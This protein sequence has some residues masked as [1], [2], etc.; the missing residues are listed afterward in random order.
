MDS[1]EL[2]PVVSK[3][4]E[5]DSRYKFG[6]YEFI[7][8]A[9]S[10]AVQKH[11]ANT[12]PD[13]SH[14]VTGQQLLEYIR[15]YALK[16]FGPMAFDLLTDWGVKVSLDFGYIVYNLIECGLLS[17]TETDSIEDFKA[18]YCFHTAFVKPFQPLAAITK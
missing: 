10:Y 5:K 2:K 8:E 15:E 13:E 1:F 6:A 12:S 11:H 17:K 3:I 9:I 4:R 7:L 18:G 16:Q 14:H